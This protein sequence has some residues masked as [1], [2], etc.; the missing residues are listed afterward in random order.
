[1]VKWRW[2][3]YWERGIEQDYERDEF[4]KNNKRMGMIDTEE[5]LNQL[6][7]ELTKVRKIANELANQ[8]FATGRSKTQAMADWDNYCEE[9]EI[10]PSSDTTI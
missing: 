8:L 1:M 9:H 2:N 7:E 6:E 4:W 5:Y 3:R 10:L